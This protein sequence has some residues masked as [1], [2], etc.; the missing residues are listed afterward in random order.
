MLRRQRL[1]MLMKPLVLLMLRSWQWKKAET[2]S[3][4]PRIPE[5]MPLRGLRI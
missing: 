2:K 3:R 4:S 1:L 5:G